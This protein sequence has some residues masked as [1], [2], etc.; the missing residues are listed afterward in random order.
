M[1]S[2]AEHAGAPG[3]DDVEEADQRQA[4]HA[5]VA[6]QAVVGE[7]GR[8]VHG[9]ENDLEAADEVAEGEQPEAACAPAASRIAASADCV[10][11]WLASRPGSAS[12]ADSGAISAAT[13]ASTSSAPIQP[14]PVISAWVPG[15]MANW[16]KEP[17]APAMPSTWLRFSA[18]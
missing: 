9:D 7:I 6:R 1:Q 5:D 16:P 11:R 2:R 12:T 13:A 15:S 3:A 10:G 4:D 17:A 14:M 18:G 8:Q